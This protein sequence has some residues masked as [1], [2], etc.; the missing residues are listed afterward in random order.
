LNGAAE[1]YLAAGMDSYLSK[2]LSAPALFN[3]LNT[4]TASGRPKRSARRGQPA[5]DATA[6]EALR[7]FL[8]PAQLEALLTESL[9]DIGPRVG[10]LGTFLTGADGAN[11][12]KEAHDLVSVAGNCGARALSTL[13]RGIERSCKHGEMADA[14]QAFDEMKDL[15]TDAI[16]AL[17][18]LRDTMAAE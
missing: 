9:A 4:L 7:G 14:I 8:K 11:A 18:G 12:A 2:P 5:L 1:R 16:D 15:A 6:I 17:T 10:R 13:A 3:A